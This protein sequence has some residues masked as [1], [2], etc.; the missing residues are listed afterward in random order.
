MAEGTDAFDESNFEHGSLT[1]ATPLLV[2]NTEVLGPSVLTLYLSTTDTDALLFVTLLAIDREGKEE[3]LTRGWL[4]GVATALATRQP[5]GS[6]FKLMKTGSRWSRAKFMSCAFRL[7]RRRA[8]SKP[9]NA[10][11]FASKGADDEPPSNSLPLRAI[12][13]GA[14]ARLGQYHHDES[15]PSHSICR[16][17]AATYGTFSGGDISSFAPLAERLLVALFFHTRAKFIPRRD[18]GFSSLFIHTSGAIRRHRR[19]RPSDYSRTAADRHRPDRLRR[20]TC[21]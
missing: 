1:Y 15:H 5:A 17:H 20:D 12:T 6:R 14:L 18:A 9:A 19:R 7:C 4:R 2:E 21:S 16:S 3:E 11:P 8:C 13:C 10:L